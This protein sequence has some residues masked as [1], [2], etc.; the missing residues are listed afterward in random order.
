MA[1]TLAQQQELS[2]TERLCK[3]VL[4]PAF[5]SKFASRG[6][7]AQFVND[8]LS[9]IT[10]ASNKGSS[11]LTASSQKEAV[12]ANAKD[13]EDELVLS[14][15]QAQAAARVK[16]LQSSP[17]LL[18]TYL[19]GEKITQSRP[20]LESAAE[21][22]ISQTDIERPGGVDTAFVQNIQD[23]LVAYKQIEI[24]QTGHETVSMSDRATRNAFI[25]LVKE[26][27]R[28]I[29]AAA[30]SL[31]PPRTPE[32]FGNRAEFLLPLNRPFKG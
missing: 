13:A 11:A 2:K 16:H 19:I 10:A 25:K 17:E 20:T 1:L 31:Y 9:K 3:S 18:Q 32:H 27:R 5:A 29:Q 30:D 7:T 23:K 4:K 24:D 15:R 8:I 22:I 28:Q 6:I 12:T 21:T 14:L 26:A